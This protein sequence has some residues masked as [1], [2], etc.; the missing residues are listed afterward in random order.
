MKKGS[1]APAPSRRWDKSEKK[2]AVKKGSLV[3]LGVERLKTPQCGVFSEAGQSPRESEAT[4]DLRTKKADTSQCH[5]DNGTIAKAPSAGCPIQGNQRLYT[6]SLVLF[7]K[8]N[9]QTLPSAEKACII[10]TLGDSVEKT[11]SRLEFD[12]PRV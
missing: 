9:K 10:G 5:L 1:W 3:I 11:H 7:G 6:A 12:F 8:T 4:K 2:R